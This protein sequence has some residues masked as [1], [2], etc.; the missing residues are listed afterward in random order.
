[1]GV[2][3]QRHATA[4]LLQ[5]KTRYPLYGRLGEPH[6]RLRKISHLP[7]FGPRTVQPLAVRYCD[8]AISA[9]VMTRIFQN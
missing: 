1:M 9:R 3:G 5:G 6:G 4:A 8:Y 2:G 7:G